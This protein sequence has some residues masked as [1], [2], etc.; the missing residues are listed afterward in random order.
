MACKLTTQKYWETYYKHSHANKQ[1]IKTVCS[2]YN[3][4]WDM[5][6][7]NQSD[8]KSLIEIG[9]FPGRYLAYLANRYKLKPTCL[10]YNSDL[11]Q[12]EGSFVMGVPDYHIIQEDFTAY[13]PQIT[14]DYVMSNGFIEHFENYEAIL[15]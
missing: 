6:I 7:K 1:H 9:G 3:P 2:Y 14:Y 15:E 8:A 5:F 13:K 12:I 4:I 11:T 10:D